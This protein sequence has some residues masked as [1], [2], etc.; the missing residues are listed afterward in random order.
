M[1]KKKYKHWQPHF[2]QENIAWLCFDR[3]NETVNSINRAVLEELDD[4]LTEL[5]AMKKCAG[6]VIYSGKEKGFVAG[7]DVH[8]FKKLSDRDKILDFLAYGQTV[9]NKIEALSIPTCAMINGF[10]FGGGTEMVLACDYR[11]IEDSPSVR[12]GLPEVL[13]G[14]HPGWG[15]TVRLPKLIGPVAA[16][17]LILTGRGIRASAA[18][19]MGLVND[20][21]P[22]RHLENAAR[23]FILKQPKTQPSR[24]GKWMDYAFIRQQF[25]KLL[26]WQTGKKASVEHYPHLY[27]AID[28]WEKCSVYSHKAQQVERESIA[29]VIESSDTPGN[30]L[31]LYFLREQLKEAAKASDFEAAHVHV[32]GAGVMGGDIAAWCA[33]RGLQVSLQDRDAAAIAPAIK[34]AHALFKKKLKKPRLVQQAMD[35]L[36]PDVAGHGI[37]KADVI[38]EAIYENLEAKQA[39]FKDLE[40]QAKAS[41]IL[42]SNTSS[43]PL[44]EINSVMKNPDRLIGIHFFNPV[45]KMPLVEIVKG[46]KS[47]NTIINKA[48]AFVG[49]IDRLPLIVKSSPGFLVNR[50]LMPYLM[51]CMTCMQEGIP[52]EVIDKAALDFGMPMGPVELADTVGLDVCLSVATHLTSHFGG[53][54]PERLVKMV[55]QGKLGRKTG[56]GFYRYRKGKAVKTSSKD[57]KEHRD[58]ASRLI[59]RMVNEASACLREG[60]VGDA[61]KLDAGMVFGTGFAPFRGG[62][63]RYAQSFG[64]DKLNHLFEE[65][66]TRYGERFKQDE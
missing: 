7:A 24:I 47:K 9:F 34:R 22:E 57:N 23:H 45:A 41:A 35:R 15:G 16:M 11:I 53:D 39:L 1:L 13:L 4:L 26:R 14:I 5:K 6:L 17:N 43:I 21:V 8:D 2:D 44:D 62:P 51:E 50:V 25:A 29:N 48:S 55:E 40:K 54:V 30:L 64:E 58:I 52:A 66:E 49:Q 18:K 61:D 46:E 33:L 28:N 3:K 42:A 56:H 36:I 37:K 63:M 19:K 38:I 12:I 10:C 27:A 60:V 59:L 65:L 32:I 31:R 20:V